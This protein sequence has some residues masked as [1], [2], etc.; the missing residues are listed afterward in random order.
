M[1]YVAKEDVGWK[2][3]VYSWLQK[4]E[5]WFNDLGIDDE[6]QKYLRDMFESGIQ[7]GLSRIRG[8]A[9]G[10][11]EIPGHMQKSSTTSVVDDANTEGGTSAV[12]ISQKSELNEPIKSSDQQLVA[13]VCNILEA[14]LS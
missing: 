13:G 6:L 3:F 12:D 5:D 1:V 2:P 10:G 7:Q 4:R 9:E 11:I 8:I 14:I